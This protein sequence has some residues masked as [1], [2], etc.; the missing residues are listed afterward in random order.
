MEDAAAVGIALAAACCFGAATS[1]QHRSASAAPAGVAGRAAL[2]GY[3]LRQPWWVAG[4]GASAAGAVLHATA[5]RLGS[6]TLVQ[7]LLVTG[8]VFA[9]IMRAA[10][11]RQAP[12]AATV[13]WATVT[14]AGL[15]AFLVAANAT[16]G[17]QHPD[18]ET[19]ALIIGAGTLLAAAAQALARRR[20]GRQAGALL[21][22][23]TGVIFGLVAGVL[24]ATVNDIAQGDVMTGWALYV[25]IP[26]SAWGVLL[27]Q[28]AYHAAPLAISLPVLNIIDPLVAIVF[29]AYAFGERLTHSPPALAL[30]LAGVLAMG[31]GVLRLYRTAVAPGDRSVQ[32]PSDAATEAYR[33]ELGGRSR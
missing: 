3:L 31:L 12:A 25:L 17:Q 20:S 1:I 23:A 24:K 6:L 8:V 10:L 26:L 21:G 16:P 19:A 22:I 14:S 29:G 32:V 2:L 4:I 33:H 28:H 27:N 15:A 5:L 30:E 18:N 13:G 7:P 9:L 11:E